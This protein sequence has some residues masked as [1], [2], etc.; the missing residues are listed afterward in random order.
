MPCCQ[1][2]PPFKGRW[3][4]SGSLCGSGDLLIPLFDLAVFTHASPAI[5]LPRIQIKEA[6]NDGLDIL[7]SGS[8][9]AECL[10]CMR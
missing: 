1:K 4:A 8:R 3:I 9:Y 6:A 7:H 10:D 2:R 5:R